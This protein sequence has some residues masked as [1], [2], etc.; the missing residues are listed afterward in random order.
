MSAERLIYVFATALASV[1]LRVSGSHDPGE[2]ACD[3]IMLFAE[4]LF[5][6]MRY[7]QQG[8]RR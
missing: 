1:G 6:G 2:I 8:Y 5:V 3:V 7:A 4:V